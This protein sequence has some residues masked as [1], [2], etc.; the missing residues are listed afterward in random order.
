MIDEPLKRMRKRSLPGRLR[1][2]GEA[3]QMETLGLGRYA[4]CCC[5]AAA[6]LAPKLA[7]LE[8]RHVQRS[9]RLLLAVKIR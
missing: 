7:R 2:L 6:L 8:N 5:V 4:L 9:C 3:Q 1:E